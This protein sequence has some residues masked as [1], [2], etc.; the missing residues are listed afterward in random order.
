MYLYYTE[1]GSDRIRLFGKVTGVTKEE[2][3]TSLEDRKFRDKDEGEWASQLITASAGLDYPVSKVWGS[4]GQVI[5]GNQ[6]G[7]DWMWDANLKEEHETPYNP[8]TDNLPHNQAINLLRVRVGKLISESTGATKTKAV[9]IDDIV[10]CLEYLP[11]DSCDEDPKEEYK[12]HDES[13]LPR[14]I[15]VSSSHDSSEESDCRNISKEQ[16]VDAL[17]DPDKNAEEE[18]MHPVAAFNKYAM[19]NGAALE[20]LEDSGRK[21]TL[22]TKRGVNILIR[23]V[24]YQMIVDAIN[25]EELDHDAILHIERDDKLSYSITI[26]EISS[27][28]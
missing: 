26:S 20:K 18:Y 17:K 14:K 3:I 24:E 9:E 6:K 23:E 7:F 16:W 12:E 19:E 27:I 5:L 21:Y 4:E 11:E 8:E 13:P 28:V 2:I 22:T 1:K 25:S 10:G 15:Y